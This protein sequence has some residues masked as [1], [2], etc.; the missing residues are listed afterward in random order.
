MKAF[1]SL[2]KVTE[3]TQTN[4]WTYLLERCMLFPNIRIL[5]EIRNDKRI[6]IKLTKECDTLSFT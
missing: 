4:K 2:E 6:N 3:I 1:Q 5:R